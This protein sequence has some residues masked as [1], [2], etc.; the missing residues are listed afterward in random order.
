MK[1]VQKQEYLSLYI[2]EKSNAN[3]TA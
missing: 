3:K 2:K 1:E